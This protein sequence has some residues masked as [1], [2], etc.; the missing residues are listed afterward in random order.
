MFLFDSC[1]SGTIFDVTRARIR[2]NQQART[3]PGE[4]LGR[5]VRLF[6]TAGDE[7]QM[8]P[9]ESRF[10][11]AVVRALKG[12]AD[13][14]SDGLILGS[15]LGDF[16]AEHG[17]TPH[18]SPQWGVLDIPGYDAG[19]LAFRIPEYDASRAG[20]GSASTLTEE[21]A[22]WGLVAESENTGDLRRFLGD[23][24]DGVFAALAAAK[25]ERLTGSR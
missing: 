13:E 4:R 24:P 1:F 21:L 20:G 5:P 10:R 11:A 2:V 3:D 12:F 15:E 23:Y 14:D 18:N 9:A 7:T 8:V 16:V 6:V 19:D 17:A 22:L 25:I